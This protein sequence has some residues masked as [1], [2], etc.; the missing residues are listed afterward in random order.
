MQGQLRGCSFRGRGRAANE[1]LLIE[2]VR[3]RTTLY[4]VVRALSGDLQFRNVITE[5]ASLVE[6]N[7]LGPLAPTWECDVGNDDLSVTTALSR[8]LWWQHFDRNLWPSFA[9][10]RLLASLRV[11]IAVLVRAGYGRGEIGRGCND[12]HVCIALAPVGGAWL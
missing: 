2:L 4:R 5:K 8:C 10:K 1:S 9:S 12:G 7:Q 11:L 3:V 6:L